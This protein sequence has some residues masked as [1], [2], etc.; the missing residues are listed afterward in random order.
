MTWATIGGAI[1]GL[2]FF[3]GRTSVRRAPTA[4]AAAPACQE[5]ASPGE[6][7][8]QALLSLFRSLPAAPPPGAAADHAE[9]DAVEAAEARLGRAEF[10]LGEVFRQLEFQTRAG[11]KQAEGRASTVLPFL[12]G[13]ITGAV[14]ADPGMREAFSRQFTTSLCD[15]QLEDDQA[16]S[17]AHMAMILPDITTGKGIDCFFS[18]AKEGVPFWTMLDAWRRS[19]LASSPVLDAIRVSATDS[20]TTRRFLSQEEAIAQR[21]STSV[22]ISSDDIA[23]ASGR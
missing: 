14:Q 21:A 17:V 13:M 1:V 22:S 15:R 23:Q 7:R 3:A 5:V 18:K 16:I 19:G 10:L 8:E 2:A 6:R 4:S 11:L 12:H 9:A 20:R